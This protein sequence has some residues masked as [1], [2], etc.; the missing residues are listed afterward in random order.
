[1]RQP[2]SDTP[3]KKIDLSSTQSLR[4]VALRKMAVCFALIEEVIQREMR[5]CRLFGEEGM[6]LRRGVFRA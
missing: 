3:S 2:F 4:K 6:R 5:E 1:M